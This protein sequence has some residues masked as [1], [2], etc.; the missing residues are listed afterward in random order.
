MAGEHQKSGWSPSTFFRLMGLTDEFTKSD[1][2]IFFATIGWTVVCFAVFLIFT[3]G[4]FSFSLSVTGWLK[5]WQFYVMLMFVVGILITVWLSI[6]G[7]RDTF[8]LFRKLRETKRNY[9]D[10]GRVVNGRN[11]GE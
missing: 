11:T 2:V 3:L 7:V 10:D 5:M 1:R 8:L 4:H 6:G 9:E